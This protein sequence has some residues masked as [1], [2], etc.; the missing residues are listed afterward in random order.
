MPGVGTSAD[1]ISEKMMGSSEGRS[2][3]LQA[4]NCL[5]SVLYGTKQ[6][7]EAERLH[8]KAQELAGRQPYRQTQAMT[9]MVANPAPIKSQNS[10]SSS[11]PPASML[12]CFSPLPCLWA[13][14]LLESMSF[15]SESWLNGG[16]LPKTSSFSTFPRCS[17]PR[18]VSQCARSTR[19]SV[20]SLGRHSRGRRPSSSSRVDEAPAQSNSWQDSEHPAAAAKCKGVMPSSS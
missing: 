18:I 16:V 4:S 15:P 1:S 6:Q 17:G 7:R 9:Q 11:A 19:C 5:R 10:M 3:V 2:Q 20:E 13:L 12:A 14:L 8:S